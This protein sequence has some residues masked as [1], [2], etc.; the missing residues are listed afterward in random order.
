MQGTAKTLPLWHDVT[1]ECADWWQA[2]PPRHDCDAVVV[3][4]GIAGLGIALSLL[5]EGREVLLVDRA[6]VGAGETLRTSAHLA[7]ALDDRFYALARH[8]GR[9]GARLAAESH[10]AAIDWIERLVATGDDGCGFRRVP[11]ILFPHDGDP[12][13]LE[14]EYPAARK[15]GLQVSYLRDGWSEMPALGPVLRFEGQARID[16]G[17]YLRL[18]ARAVRDAG[19]RFLRAEAVAVEGGA[20]PVVELRGGG[21]LRARQVAV[22]ANVPFHDTGA[23]YLKQAPYR[24][25][26][27][28]GWAPAATIPDALYWDDADP[29]HYVRLVE[30]PADQEP[31]EIGVI[32]GGEDHKVGQDDDPQAY[33]RLQAWTRAR[34]PTVARFTHAW[35]GQVLE[36]A[37][38]LGYIGADPDHDN[39]FIATGD[40]GN[41]LT[42]GTIAGMLVGELMLGRDNPWTELYDPARRRW[43]A[44]TSALR[45]NAN[46]AAQ[47]RDWLAPSDLDDLSALTAGNG[48]VV[49]RGLHRVAVYRDGEGK[50]HAHNARCPHMGCVVRWSGEEK[51]W[52]CPCHGSRFEARSGAILNGPTSEPLAPYDLDAE[53]AHA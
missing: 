9:D 18:L 5:R 50:L 48:A 7:S 29:Y 43:T 15:S 53:D 34:F 45:E 19:A 6:G 8:H 52:D 40:S 44:S 16:I 32:V 22:A 12:G 13:M 27:V 3:G 26:V 38:G 39:V 4:A 11:G 21:S 20:A 10:G 33:A 46:A 51:S 31:G 47:Y 37:D 1:G 36:P 24:S 28:V 42:H 25:H 49:R 35:S 17:R 41:G 30:P 14:R 2:A 23:T